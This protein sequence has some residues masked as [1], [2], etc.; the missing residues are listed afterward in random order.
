MRSP[1]SRWDLGRG[2]RAA[3]PFGLAGAIVPIAVLYGLFALYWWFTGAPTF[4]R[5]VDIARI[6]MALPGPVVGCA[7]I[8]ACAGWVTY[9]LRGNFR[10]VGTLAAITA[11]SLVL[12]GIIG[13]ASIWDQ[14]TPPRIRGVRHPMFYPSELMLLMGPPIVAAA[15]VTAFR[16]RETPSQTSGSGA[17]T[18]TAA[19]SPHGAA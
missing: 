19:S 6:R 3:V 8:G 2:F 7:T 16:A 5:R 14:L 17:E 11:M 18:S 15:L 10:F 4:I 1:S 9:S 13:W 12:W